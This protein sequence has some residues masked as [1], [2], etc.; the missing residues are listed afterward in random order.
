M[1]QQYIKPLFDTASA[2]IFIILALPI[3]GIVA[4]VIKLYDGGP[5]VFKQ[6]RFG[7]HKEPFTVY[8][9]RTMMV[10]APKN[11]PTNSLK[12]AK[13]YITPP[14]KVIRK[15]SLD[16][17]PQL[18]NVLKGDMSLVGPRPVVLKEID[19]IEERDKYN[20]NACKPGITG[21]AQVNGRDEVRLK[22]KAKMDG[23][24][25]RKLSP[26][27][28]AKCLALTLWAVLSIKG[29]REGT[30]EDDIESTLAGEV[31]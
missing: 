15:L 11:S 27:M 18:I 3:A 13:S 19:L 9:F 17:L 8:K 1:Y 29:H 25:M 24:Y 20:A 5:I 10:E 2:T 28:D 12:N 7:K 22:Q 21:W 31:S 26:V 30:D 23:H 14:G 6:K 4:V 16:E